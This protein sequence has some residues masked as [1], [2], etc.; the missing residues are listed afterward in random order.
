VL[1][2]I[3]INKTARITG[4]FDLEEQATLGKAPA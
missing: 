3:H 2:F 4:H 1:V